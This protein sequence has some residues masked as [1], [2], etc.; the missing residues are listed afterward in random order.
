MMKIKHRLFLVGIDMEG[1]YALYLSPVFSIL[2][3]E[4]INGGNWTVERI[5][6]ETIIPFN[7]SSDYKCSKTLFTLSLIKTIQYPH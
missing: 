1:C 4:I 3:K 5:R 6:L 2:K 7:R